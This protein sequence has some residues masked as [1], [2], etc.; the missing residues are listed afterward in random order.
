MRRVSTPYWERLRALREEKGLSQ[1]ELFRRTEGVGFD[2]I[3][4]LEQDPTRAAGSGK[5]SRARYPS[6]ETLESLSN[7]LGVDPSVFPEYRLAKTRELL[8][9]RL[10]EGGL[11]QAWSN[12]Q[13]FI[14]GLM[15]LATQSAKELESTVSSD[16]PNGATDA[17][18]RSL[19]EA[20]RRPSG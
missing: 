16:Q 13:Q 5:R 2:T 6:P 10:I 14:A 17:A 7:A 1:A 15:L 4:A 3:R 19:L 8:D 18:V 11:D 9:E 20:R 12:Y